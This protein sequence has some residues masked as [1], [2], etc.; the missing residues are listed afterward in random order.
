MA[1]S[2]ASSGPNRH[3]ARCLAVALLA[4]A[5]SAV[6]RAATPA[7]PNILFILTDDQSPRSVSAYPE[8]YPWVKTPHTDQLA[9]E[10]VRFAP[11][12]I[13]ANCIPARATLLTGLHST[14]IQSLTRA[15]QGPARDGGRLPEFWPRVFRRHGYHTAHIGK[16]HTDGG[17][18]HGV[19]WD[20]QKTWSRLV[21]GREANLNYQVNQLISTNGGP[22]EPAPGYSTD[23]YTRWAV[24][25]LRERGREPG[26]PWY[27][28]LCYD[29]PHGP[30]IPADRHR[31]DYP[32]VD[33]PTPAG[34]YPPRPGKPGYMQHVATWEPGPGGTPQLRER[35]YEADGVLKRY[36]ATESFPRS[37]PD[38]VRRYQQTVSAV[39]EGVG[40]VLRALDDI[41]QRENTLVVFT[42]DQGLA[43]GQHGFFD[44]HAP[45]DATIA[46]PLIVRFPGRAPAGATCAA[47]VGGVDL[48]P[49]FFR[50]AGIPLPWPMHGRDL[51][52]LLERPETPWPHP[53]LLP[54]TIGAW[55][56]DTV[57][58]PDES[59]TPLPARGFRVPWW[60]LYREGRYKYIRTLVPGEFEEVY[61]LA[62][63]PGEQANLATDA[64]HRATVERLRA[65]ALA[66]LR[67]TGASFTERLPPVGQSAR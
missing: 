41:G 9:R 7:R 53:T 47:T 43:I 55:G 40:A 39:D 44:K 51:T 60:V 58:I 29:A 66:E 38:W 25:Y 63:D 26:R 2:P 4:M 22:P 17:T 3:L 57:R 30:F 27:L 6:L 13:G 36:R 21:G 10:G 16:W 33:V 35:H 14:G 49:T 12:Y 1:S 65:A 32:V 28:W 15:A 48:V 56:D 64:R 8:A 45:Y 52:P 62:S 61:D 11:A 5:T 67:R 18:G 20:F 24:E 31:Q 37:L 54:Y 42:S 46:A 50:A 23:N 19:D 34:I 59:A